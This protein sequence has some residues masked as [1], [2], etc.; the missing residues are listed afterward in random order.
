MERDYKLIKE[1]FYNKYEIEDV[2]G[3]L[4]KFIDQ[5]LDL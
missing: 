1:N 2:K 3:Q 4:I 5:E